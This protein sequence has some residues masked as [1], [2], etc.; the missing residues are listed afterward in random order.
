VPRAIEAIDARWLPVALVLCGWLGC[1]GAAGIPDGA[2]SGG[3]GGSAAT[4]GAGGGGRPSGGSSGTGGG[5]SGGIGATGGAC[6]GGNGTGGNGTGGQG[7]GGTSGAAG[8][9]G[10]GGNGTGGAST[11]GGFVMPNP[12]ASGLPN[13]ASYDTSVPGVVLDTVTGLMWERSVNAAP[14]SGSS[15]CVQGAAAD[16]CS[17]KTTGG[18]ADWRLP[19]VLEL[20][21]LVDFTVGSP[22]PTIDAAAFPGTPAENFWTSMQFAGGG[23]AP[24][25]WLVRFSSGL[26]YYDISGGTDKFRVRC[27]RA[28]APA[29]GCSAAPRFTVQGT[30]ATATV[31][32]AATKLVWQQARSATTMI[33]DD[34]QVYCAAPFRLPSV[35]ELQTIIDYATTNNARGLASVD[36]A[37]FPD[38]PADYF[39]SS[40][41]CVDQPGVWIVD[42]GEGTAGCSGSSGPYYVRCVR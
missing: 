31:T 30:G 2:G 36:P 3:S 38:T 33:L 15:T 10:A 41:A 21:S 25:G 7:T 19:T 13:P 4:A 12:V 9:A 26:T 35:K 5:A 40:S 17:G 28:P 16:Y 23:S 29:A 6:T 27:V 22:G 34:A 39:L 11:C 14:C 20:V 42:F 1:G 32:D 18:H 8:G 37:S 24:T